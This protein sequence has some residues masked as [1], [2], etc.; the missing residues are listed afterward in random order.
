MQRRKDCTAQKMRLRC[1]TDSAINWASRYREEFER[2][3]RSRGIWSHSLQ[4][5]I[6]RAGAPAFYVQV[7][8]ANRTKLESQ[9]SVYRGVR[10][11]PVQMIY[12]EEEERSGI[13]IGG[14]RLRPLVCGAGITAT[15][16]GTLGMFVKRR[17]GSVALISA[18]QVL[19]DSLPRSAKGKP[20][21]QPRQSK[22][23]KKSNDGNLIARVVGFTKCSKRPRGNDYK[24]G[25]AVLF[26]MLGQPPDRSAFASIWDRIQTPS[27]RIH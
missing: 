19:G 9:E 7:D 12:T 17:D 2:H 1:C 4:I 8:D 24:I 18:G 27:L 11:M 13:R 23:T 14:D 5:G 10:I 26:R 6:D 22:N 15:Q 16:S 20:V 21:F 25:C 3:L